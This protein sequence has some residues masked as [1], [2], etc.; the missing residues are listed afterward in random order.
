MPLAGRQ[1]FMETLQFHHGAD[2]PEDL[3]FKD[4]LSVAKGVELDNATAAFIPILG[5]WIVSR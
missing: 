5:P 1:T 4:G 3:F 2:E